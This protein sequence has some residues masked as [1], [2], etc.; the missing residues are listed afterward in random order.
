MVR[1][2]KERRRSP[3]AGEYAILECEHIQIL[4]PL[5]VA[6]NGGRILSVLCEDC[7]KALLLPDTVSEIEE[8][9]WHGRKAPRY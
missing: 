6:I 2:I 4:T 1:K 5:I 3:T 8:K 7:A 9:Y